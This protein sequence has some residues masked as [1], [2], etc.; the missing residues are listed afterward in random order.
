MKIYINLSLI[1]FFLIIISHL[2]LANENDFKTNSIINKTREIAQNIK[3]L[4]CQNQSI[5]ES[6]SELAKDLKKLIK[7]KLEA[8][9][10]ENDVYKFLRARYGDYILLKPPLNK[11][12]ILLWF[13]PFIILVFSTVYITKFFKK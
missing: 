7:E 8:G 12:T 6:N 4:V 9:L 10:N 2:A 5:D 1:S 13:L 11:N 3:C